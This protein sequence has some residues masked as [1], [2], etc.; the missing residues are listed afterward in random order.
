[1]QRAE[2]R[3]L[4]QEVPVGIDTAHPLSVA[5]RAEITEVYARYVRAFDSGDVEGC[6]ELFTE[7]GTFTA[8][9]RPPVVGREALAGFFAA[10]IRPSVVTHHIVSS[11]VIEAVSTGGARGSAHVVAL[12]V[13]GDTVRLAAMG[14]YHD[15]F[16]RAGG[17][18][19]LRARRIES[20]VPG[21]LVGAVLAR[22]D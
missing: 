18:W 19:V 21:S 13:D 4:T 3:T 20:C 2:R 8:P 6:L 7:D 9:G 22:P 11:I 10:V 12:R 17:R 1:M 5:D 14:R 16:D 15:V